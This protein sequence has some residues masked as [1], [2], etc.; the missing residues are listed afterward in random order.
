MKKL[1]LVVGLLLL[2]I[3]ANAD[4]TK[5]IF[6]HLKDTSNIQSIDVAEGN[7]FEVEIINTC[8]D[9]FK[10]NWTVLIKKEEQQ[11]TS[12]K[13]PERLKVTD[14]HKPKNL[15]HMQKYI[16]KN[17]ACSID[18]SI[19]LKIPHDPKYGGYRIDVVRNDKPDKPD[20]PVKA[21]KYNDGQTEDTINAELDKIYENAASPKDL[22]KIEN[23][24][25]KYIGKNVSHDLRPT[26]FVVQVNDSPWHFDFAGGFTVS[27]L[28]DQK[29]GVDS[30]NIVYR[31]KSAED[32]ANLGFAAFLHT[33]NDRW[34]IPGI[35]KFDLTLVPISLGLG[36]TT[37]SRASYFLGPSIKMGKAFFTLGWN[38]GPT[39]TLPAGVNEGA[40]V[41]D[42]N[43]LSN[44]DTRTGGGFFFALSYTFLG[45]GTA[46]FQK[47]F[48]TAT[49]K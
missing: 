46:I 20:V 8:T 25:D 14:S 38:L 48:A 37:G 12:S 35:N 13:Q 17:Q 19:V 39:H 4:V 34:K 42:A 47:P 36:I 29:Y 45:S 18:G 44:M 30:S 9:K 22:A 41:T 26:Y 16:A 15:Y 7:Y 43:A 2:P 40:H 24:Q 21:I 49:G 3:T 1:L 10:A 6:D 27:F 31:N 5:V 11:P 28:T 32:L 23:E 33:Y